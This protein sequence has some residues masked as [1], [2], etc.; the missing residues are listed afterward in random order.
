MNISCQTQILK[1]LLKVI[2]ILCCFTKLLK[3]VAFH[4]DTP[5]TYRNKLT[6]S[7]KKKYRSRVSSEI[8]PHKS[9]T[10]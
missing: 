7:D 4:G 9:K 6:L 3:K 1:N 8:K 10:P 2:G 5:N